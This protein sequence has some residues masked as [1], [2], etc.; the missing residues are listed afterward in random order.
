MG[1]PQGLRQPKTEGLAWHKEQ[2]YT[3][4]LTDSSTPDATR[5]L[6]TLTRVLN[7]VSSKILPGT[8]RSVMKLPF[9]KVN[10]RTNRN[11]QR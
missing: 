1:N 10:S 8:V 11:L 3:H 2:D 6:D 7:S 9:T 4:T 5:V